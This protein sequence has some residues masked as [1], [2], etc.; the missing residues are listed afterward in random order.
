[1]RRPVG[2]VLAA[3]LIAASASV[4]GSSPATSAAAGPCAAWMDKGKSPAKRADALVGA[5]DLDQKLHM[6]TFSDPP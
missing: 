4:V 1:M 6:L 5:M 3:V 2:A